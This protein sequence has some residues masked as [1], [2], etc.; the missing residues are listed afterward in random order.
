[1]TD[2]YTLQ[3]DSLGIPCTI[4]RDGVPLLYLSTDVGHANVD[5]AAQIVA[6][7]NAHEATR[8]RWRT[9]QSAPKGGSWIVIR[10][11]ADVFLLA[12]WDGCTWI[13][14]EGVMFNVDDDH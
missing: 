13:D 14:S 9:M 6:K 12:Q 3:C 2:R 11:E 7:L 4:E 1:M 8:P 5:N 10:V